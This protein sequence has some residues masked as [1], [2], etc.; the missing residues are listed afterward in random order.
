V[1]GLPELD[2]DDFD[3]AIV[4]TR[5]RVLNWIKRERDFELAVLPDLLTRLATSFRP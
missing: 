2:D 4:A 1:I 3:S 5:R